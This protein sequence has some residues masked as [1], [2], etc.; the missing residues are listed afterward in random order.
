MVS[1]PDLGRHNLGR[2]NNLIGILVDWGFGAGLT[3]LD[4]RH[5]AVRYTERPIRCT[6][7]QEC[8][9]V[10]FPVST[11]EDEFGAEYTTRAE[12]CHELSIKGV[13]NVSCISYLRPLRVLFFPW[14]SQTFE[15]D[16][17]RYELPI[18][19]PTGPGGAGKHKTS[20][21]LWM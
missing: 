15:V 5:A 4:W 17:G 21:I 2:Q 7:Q 11:Y 19:N 8:S 3:C 20:V 6:H 10:V 9:V 1:R 14:T 12:L 13:R 18:P 16:P